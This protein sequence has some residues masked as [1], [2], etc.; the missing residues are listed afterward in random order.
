MKKIFLT[1]CVAALALT[2]CGDNATKAPKSEAG[3]TENGVIMEQDSLVATLPT[4]DI[5]YLNVEY[6]HATCNLSKSEGVALETKI[7]KSME[8][9]A[10]KEKGLQAEDT[11]I[12]KAYANLQEKYSK[13]LITSMDAQKEQEK[14]EARVEKMQQNLQYLQTS[15]QKETAALQEELAVLNNRLA[16]YITKAVEEINKDGRYKMIIN[17]GM[18]IDA[19]ESLDMTGAVLAKV[20]ELYAAD[21]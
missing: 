9:F 2:A 5:A 19:D 6:I 12:Q 18:L 13:G 20:N 3:A 7:N 4:G 1:L 21:K 14:L 11:S 8:T 15:Y 10:Q 16:D 17:A